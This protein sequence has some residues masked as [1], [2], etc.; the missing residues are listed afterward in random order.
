MT[1]IEAISEAARIC[2]QFGSSGLSTSEQKTLCGR[3]LRTFVEETLCLHHEKIEFTP[4]TIAQPYAYQNTALY[5][6]NDSQVADINPNGALE[7][8]EILAVTIQ[9]RPIAKGDRLDPRLGQLQLAS[10]KI[11]PPECWYEISREQWAT[12]PLLADAGNTEV[13]GTLSA[14]FQHKAI[15]SS[16]S[17]A[18]PIRIPRRLEELFV[19]Y[20]VE[21]Y[22]REI[23][24][25]DARA[26]Y[27]D[28]MA[29][30]AATIAAVRTENENAAKSIMFG[31]PFRDTMPRWRFK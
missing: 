17:D 27:M 21:G 9:D 23:Q 13:V 2:N 3:R 11:T 6:L 20:L 15:T 30:N 5:S 29:R 14:F 22:L 7:I 25:G 4:K 10:V 28:L 19:D 1:L 16:T 24:L 12:Y 18:E 26:V 31:S 8:I